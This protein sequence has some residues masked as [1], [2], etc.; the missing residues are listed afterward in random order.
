MET[1]PTSFAEFKNALLEYFSNPNTVIQ[2]Q[3]EFNTI[4]QNTGRICP[5]HP[6][7]LPEAVTL[8]KALESAEKKA[9]HSQIVNMVIE[10]NKTETLEKRVTQLGKELPKKIESYLIPDPRNTYQPPQ[11]CSQEKR[12]PAIFANA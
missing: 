8:A 1:K 11:K 10:K 12:A 4:K 3:N 6:N 5:A 2:L 9:N 7:S